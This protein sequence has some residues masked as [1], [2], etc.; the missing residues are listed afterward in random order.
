MKQEN[1]IDAKNCL[2][3]ALQLSETNPIQPLNDF[4][5]FV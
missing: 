3:Y 5:R 1:L 4:P 2:M